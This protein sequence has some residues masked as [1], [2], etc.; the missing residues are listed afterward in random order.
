MAFEFDQSFDPNLTDD[1]QIVAMCYANKYLELHLATATT[2]KTWDIQ[3]GL[4]KRVS[5]GYRDI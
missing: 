3:H 1:N 2:L 5:K 4:L